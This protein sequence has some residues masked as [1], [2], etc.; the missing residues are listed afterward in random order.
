VVAVSMSS[1]TIRQHIATLSFSGTASASF[2]VWGDVIPGQ[3]ITPST[4][5][6]QWAPL[7]VGGTSTKDLTL[8]NS[9]SRPVPHHSHAQRSGLQTG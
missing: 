8:T 4:Y 9:S 7:L 3:A 5:Q 2:E 1:A 6:F